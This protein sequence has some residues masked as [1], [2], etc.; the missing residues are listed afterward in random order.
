MT[1]IKVTKKKLNQDIKN[2]DHR[3]KKLKIVIKIKVFKKNL[4]KGMTKSRLLRKIKK[5]YDQNKG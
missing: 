1:K 3:E 4:N 2:Q 5:K